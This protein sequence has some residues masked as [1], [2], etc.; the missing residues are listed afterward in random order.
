MLITKDSCMKIY[1]VTKALYLEMNA[2]GVSLGPVYCRCKRVWTKGVMKSQ[3]MWPPSQLLLQVKAYQAQSGGT[4]TLREKQRLYYMGSKSYIT[5][6]LWKK[7]M[8]SLA[9]SYLWSWLVKILQCYCN[10]Y[11]ASCYKYT[12]TVCAFCKNWSWIVF[13]KLSVMPQP[14]G[15]PRPGWWCSL[16]ILSMFYMLRI[17]MHTASWKGTTLWHTIQT[18]GGSWC[19]HIHG[20]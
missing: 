18:M 13:S 6:A 3:I 16:Q 1:E 14:H 15:E 20:K 4:A 9:K 12:R 11:S 8:S 19:W 10:I 17:P 2:S 7:C 5:T